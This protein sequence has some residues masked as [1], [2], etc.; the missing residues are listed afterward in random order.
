MVKH[1]I[2]ERQILEIFEKNEIIQSKI[3]IL[4]TGNA[5]NT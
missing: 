4:K 5:R 1:E 2:R 3:E